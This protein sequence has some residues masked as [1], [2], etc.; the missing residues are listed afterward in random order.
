MFSTELLEL[1]EEILNLCQEKKLRLASVESCT[2]GLIAACL[3]EVP[4]SSSMFDR[5]F[6]T[7]SN[8]SKNEL[9]QV[10]IN[11]I[12]EHGAVSPEVAEA[13]ALGG[14]E[15]SQVDIVVSATGIAGPD[16]GSDEKPLGL[17]YIGVANRKTSAIRHIKNN[18]EGNRTEVRQSTVKKALRVFLE[19]IN[20][21]DT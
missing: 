9:V 6:I 10:P 19:E 15:K 11:T 2:G 5:G 18:F 14:L 13:M 16:G 7:Y 12:Q 8:E 3:T 1:T 20:N 17:V 4:G 21:V